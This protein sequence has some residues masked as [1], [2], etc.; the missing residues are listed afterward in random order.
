MLYR[1]LLGVFLATS[2]ALSGLGDDGGS[3]TFTYISG[4][5]FCQ[6]NYGYTVP[7]FCTAP[8]ELPLGSFP[9]PQIGGFYVDPNFGAQVRLLTD[10]TTDSV[11]QYSTPSALSATG[12]YALLGK[13]D[14]HTRIV[15]VATGNIVAADLTNVTDLWAGLWSPLTDDVLYVLGPSRGGTKIFKYQVSTAT[16]TLLVDYATDGHNFSYIT[17]GG[18][19]DL[20]ADNWAAFFAPNEH[21]VC[22]VDL[23]LVRTYC[24]DYTAPNPNNKVGWGFLDY[25]LITKGKEVDT[26]KRYVL[27]MAQPAMGVYSVNEQTGV[28]DFEFRG[29]EYPAGVQG[30]DAPGVG[31]K[32]GICDPG[33]YCLND[34]HADVFAD[35]GH[36]YMIT[37]IGVDLPACEDDLASMQI[38][39]GIHMLTSVD[40][41]GGRKVLFKLFNCGLT[42]SSIHIGCAKSMSAFC[43]TE[44]DTP[45]HNLPQQVRDGKSPFDSEIIVV[46]GNGVEARRLAMHRSIQIGYWDQP[47][48][49]ISQDG[50]QVLWDSNFGNPA[51]HRVAV[52]NTGWG[53]STPPPPVCTY[54]LNPTSLSVAA[55][56]GSGAIVVVPSANT[57]PSPTASSNSSWVTATA[58]GNTVNWSVAANGGLQSRIGS[59]NV[60]GQTVDVTQSGTVVVVTMTLFPSTLILGTNGTV[61]TAPQPVSLTFA[62]GTGTSWTASS[63]QP[64][65]TVSPTSG[66]GDTTLMVSATPGSGGAITIN[67]PGASNSPQK[68]Q[69]QISAPTVGPPFGSFDSPSNNS[70]VSAAIA[71]TGWA[72]DAIGITKV[73]IWREPIGSEPPGLQYI[74]DAVFVS[75]ARPDVASSFPSYPSAD[76]A[77]WGYLLLTNFLPNANGARGSANGTYVLHALAHNRGGATVDLGSKT[78]VVDNADAT[79]PFGTIDTPAQGATVWGDAYLNF[80][81]ALTPMPDSIPTDGS[82]ITVN[83]D[84]ITVGHPNYNQF[85][86]DIASLFPGYANSNGAI[87]FAYV[88][89]TR[90]TNGL[91]SISW[92]VWD[93]KIRGNG[94]GSRFFNVLNVNSNGTA[95]PIVT[96]LAPLGDEAPDVSLPQSVIAAAT[97]EELS[98]DIEE[99]DRIEV[100][101]GGTAGYV[102]ANGLR[103]PLPVGS[104]LQGGVFYWQL[105]PVFLGEYNL[106]FERPG[107]RPAHLRV[108]VHPKTYSSGEAAVAQ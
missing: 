49:S 7:A 45:E 2:L 103:Q 69:V 98:M 48:A 89:T 43:V 27:L 5:N 105:A 107:A 56:G 99:M 42:W 31:N 12:K 76:R 83:V 65:I 88:D 9:I 93:N 20:S 59:L 11:H 46:R 1:T 86:G 22:A 41:G 63:N 90:L 39:T 81:W 21:Q 40:S 87:G 85:R 34:P 66:I 33:E 106:V 25:V 15:E 52:A 78:I 16:T 82:T 14:G 97:G 70:R 80:G 74:G 67:A 8:G 26:N 62:G 102:V 13:L 50:S 77:G 108:V 24:I 57:C 47:R 92:G 32:D 101:V 18:T 17:N 68:V 75:G 37:D 19:G 36:Q 51:D 61:T 28:L 104:T 38:S 30:G 58:S 73:D 23:N 79:V 44:N 53:S 3:A 60:A 29:G 100:P 95:A 55:A 6:A 94:I 10:G 4:P 71:V 35:N 54:T 72:L 84:G 91:H 64:N 96:S